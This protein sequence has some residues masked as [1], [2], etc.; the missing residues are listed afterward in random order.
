MGISGLLVA[1]TAFSLLVTAQFKQLHLAGQALSPARALALAGWP[2]WALALAGLG[3]AACLAWAEWSGRG[4]TELIAGRATVWRAVLMV[5]VMLWFGHALL[6]PGLLVVGDS[7]SHIARIAHLMDAIAGGQSLVWDNDFFAGGPLLMFTGPVFHWLAAAVGLVLGDA[8][9]AVRVVVL[10]GRMASAGLMY[11]FLRRIGAGR[12]AAFLGAV[13]YGGAFLQTYFYSIRGT[14]PQVINLAA[15]PAILLCLETVLVSGRWLGAGWSGLC[16]AASLMIGNHQPTALLAGL[17]TAIYAM[18]RLFQLGWTWRRLRALLLAGAVIPLAAIYFVL[19]FTAEKSWTADDFSTRIIALCRPDLSHLLVWG[20]AGDAHSYAAYLGLSVLFVALAGGLAIRSARV[21]PGLR[22]QWW[23]FAALSAFSLV[24]TGAYVRETLFTVFFLSVTAALAIQAC[25][26][27][28]PRRTRLPALIFLMFMIDAGP[29]AVQPW[30]RLD[31]G[32]L[33]RAGIYLAAQAPVQR[34]LEVDLGKAPLQ[35]P[36]HVRPLHVPL[37][38]GA[39]PLLYA[40]V[41]S[42]YGP[43]KMDSTQ[44]HNAMVA[45]SRLAETDLAR[46]GRLSPAVAGL[47]SLYNVGWVVG[48]DGAHP[49]LP[50]DWPGV[51]IDPVLGPVLRLA[52]ATPFVTSGRLVPAARPDAFGGIPFWPAD[53]QAGPGQAP[54]QAAEQADLAMWSRMDVDLARRQAAR[55]LIQAG[56]SAPD[57]V[58][59]AA[60][61]PAPLAV[62]QSYA[63]LP[64]RVDLVVQSD[65][66]GFIRLA[67]PW[68]PSLAVT[69]DGAAVRAVPDIASMMV[70]PLHPGR[71]AIAIVAQASLLR[72][73]CLWITAI[74]MALLFMAMLAGMRPNRPALRSAADA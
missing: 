54:G 57:W 9:L 66:A 53:F 38:P 8:S 48:L 11:G 62:A 27:V 69:L 59:G 16:L 43:H 45:A 68:F 56:P 63:V 19:P 28:A 17:Y 35:G 14:F 47:L 67:H 2:A 4:L 44:A 30:T 34:V 60:D 10:A 73:C 24:I 46:S 50:A 13:F 52:T 40:R 55:L 1:L 18:T 6:A 26:H 5:C 12:G 41:Q 33:Q 23:L 42:L 32:V 36:N 37:G 22:R 20:Q 39:S 21:P 70:L 58:R 65:R 64:G 74:L 15:L 31:L 7:G 25:M 49:G 3:C 71:N 29:L 61:G 72:V 51:E